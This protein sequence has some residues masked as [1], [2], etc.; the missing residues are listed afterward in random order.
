MSIS[1][2]TRVTPQQP[3][4]RH[5]I[6]RVALLAALLGLSRGS[7]EARPT[8]VGF[9]SEAGFGV[10][11][12]L[13]DGANYAALGP[14]MEIRLGYDLTSWLSI[15]AMIGGS[16]HE[17]T[18]PPPPEGEYFQMYSAMADARLGLSIGPVQI[19][20]DGG[21][22][23]AVMS[24]NVLSQVAILDPGESL[25][26]ALRAGGGLEYQLQNRHYAF[27]IAGQ[28]MNMPGFANLQG[29]STRIYLRY[30]Y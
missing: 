23:L 22:G 29:V 5:I 8:S 24:S 16:T 27:G 2:P 25:S 11:T 28:W 12:F 17:A 18:V 26:L 6:V 30:T 9:N 10:T 19:F 7:A 21:A 15:G 13:G 3:W 4:P 20:V 1:V 14:G